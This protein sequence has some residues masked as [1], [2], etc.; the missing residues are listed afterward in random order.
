[1]MDIKILTRTAREYLEERRKR[2]RRKQIAFVDG[3][4]YKAFGLTFVHAKT[5][6]RKKKEIKGGGIYQISTGMQRERRLD[7]LQ[8]LSCFRMQRLIKIHKSK[9]DEEH[10]ACVGDCS[11]KRIRNMFGAP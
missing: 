4:F 1:M 3:G 5:K 10:G 2:K 7:P 8:Q 6:I 9:D 11:E